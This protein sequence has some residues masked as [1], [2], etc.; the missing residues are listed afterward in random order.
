M[1]GSA[2]VGGSGE[3]EGGG[4]REG[5]LRFEISEE[6]GDGVEDSKGTSTGM[7]MARCE[8]RVEGEGDIEGDLRFEISEEGAEDAAS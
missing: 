7:S 1:G 8:G 5:D 3:V 6:E 4:D 2:E